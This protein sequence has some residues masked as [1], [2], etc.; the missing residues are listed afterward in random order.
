MFIRQ[1]A[2]HDSVAVSVYTDGSE[3]ADGVGFASV[4][5]NQIIFGKLSPAT[6]IFSVELRA[7]LTALAYMLRLLSRLFDLYYDS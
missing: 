4:L 2:T 1:A 3:N 5:S 7:V 6:L